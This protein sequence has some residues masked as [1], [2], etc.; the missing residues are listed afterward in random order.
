VAPYRTARVVCV[1]CLCPWSWLAALWARAGMPWVLG[2]ALSRQALHGGKATQDTSDAQ[3]RAVWLRGGL[4]PPADGSPA[5]MCATREL[6][7][8]R[9]PRMRTRM[10]THH[11]AHTRSRRRTVPGIGERLRVVRLSDIHDRQ[12]FP[13]VPA[14]VSYCRLVQGAQASASQRYG[15]SG[16]KIGPAD[17]TWACSAAAVVFLRHHSAGQQ[18]LP[19]LAQTPGQGH[20]V[21]GCAPQWARAGDDRL[22]RQTVFARQTWLHGERS[23]CARRLTGQSGD[24]A[25]DGARS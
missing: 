11:N 6:R 15:T 21:T 3:N 20:A 9:R 13:R 4:L 12:R 5:A 16:T 18:E 14:C 17:L 2:Y 23:G 25:Q 8:R 1:A 10:A 7:R 24:E 19:R 22:R